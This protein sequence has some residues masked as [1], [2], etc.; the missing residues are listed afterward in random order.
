MNTGTNQA[1]NL[2]TWQ[3]AANLKGMSCDEVKTAIL[4]ITLQ[5]RPVDLQPAAFRL[6]TACTTG[7]V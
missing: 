3:G 6:T 7:T 2:T 5:D 1:Y 4:D